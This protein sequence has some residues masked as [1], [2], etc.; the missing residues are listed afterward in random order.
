MVEGKQSQT[1]M[2]VMLMCMCIM[3]MRSGARKFYGFIIITSYLPALWLYY[4]HISPQTGILLWLY[5][6]NS[7]DVENNP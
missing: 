2:S 7:H 3:A 4:V 1:V 6:Y 5:G